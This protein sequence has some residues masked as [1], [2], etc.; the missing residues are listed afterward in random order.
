ML[1]KEII[2][3]ILRY[4][5]VI[6]VLL[7]QLFHVGLS[8]GAQCTKEQ[9]RSRQ[10]MDRWSRW[11][12]VLSTGFSAS[13]KGEARYEMNRQ[14]PYDRYG[15]HI[16]NLLK[17]FERKKPVPGKQSSVIPFFELVK[18]LNLIVPG[19]EPSSMKEGVC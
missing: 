12:L 18:G 1:A 11:R 19:K 13:R 15:K 4:M 6:L 9:A 7:F 14:L 8:R 16:Y 3:S 2:F 10:P 17:I 5:I